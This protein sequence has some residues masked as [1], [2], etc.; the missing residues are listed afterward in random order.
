[1][2]NQAGLGYR[3]ANV[4]KTEIWSEFCYVIIVRSKKKYI[5]N[6]AGRNEESQ[7]A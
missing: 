7:T 6:D 3:F 4:A 5:F 2:D 1:L